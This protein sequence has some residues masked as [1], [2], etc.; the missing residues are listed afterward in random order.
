MSWNAR[1]GAGA[2]DH[3]H[4]NHLSLYYEGFHPLTLNNNFVYLDL[5]QRKSFT[6]GQDTHS[7]PAWVV[8]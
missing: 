4:G 3:Q 5:W 1:T 6:S 2:P 8:H 7:H